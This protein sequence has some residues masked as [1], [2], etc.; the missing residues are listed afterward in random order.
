MKTVVSIILIVLGILGIFLIIANSLAE[1]VEE[2][3]VVEIKKPDSGS[4]RGFVRYGLGK[5][6]PLE[7]VQVKFGDMSM[8][9]KSDGF[10]SFSDLPDMEE[11]LY[12]FKDDYYHIPEDVTI[13]GDTVVVNISMFSEKYIRD[14]TGFVKNYDNGMPISGAEVVLETETT[15]TDKEGKFEFSKV[16]FSRY[17]I[18]V[19]HK[20]FHSYDTTGVVVNNSYENV[21]CS[22]KPGKSFIKSIDARTYQLAEEN[23]HWTLEIKAN[24]FDYVGIKYVF[25]T[26]T[27][28]GNGEDYKLYCDLVGKGIYSLVYKGGRRYKPGFLHV[29]D[30]EGFETIEEIFYDN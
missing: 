17:R 26:G 14:I 6:H 19:N 23:F 28:A 10:Y 16:P 1:D 15:V 27:F 21:T 11:R 20:D 3:E 4:V 24:V 5:G 30:D 13:H 25:C 18:V 7:G 2:V 8:V 12:Y 9:T 29:V 22:L